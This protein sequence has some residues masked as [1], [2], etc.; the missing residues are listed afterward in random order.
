[1]TSLALPVSIHFS[2]S[3][4]STFLANSAQCGQLNEAYSRIVIGASGLPSTRSCGATASRPA[5]SA[6]G[7]GACA[8]AG[9]MPATA[10]TNSSANQISRI[11]TFL[12]PDVDINRFAPPTQR[13]PPPVHGHRVSFETRPPGA[14]QDRLAR[15]EETH[16][17][18]A[19]LQ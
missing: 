2:L 3:F 13:P 15:L 14:P 8:A 6:G 18:D 7:F 4:G 1:M 16:D 10:A 17:A 12:L 11:G 9:T 5:A 19:M